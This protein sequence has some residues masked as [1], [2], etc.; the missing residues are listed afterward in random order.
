MAHP[1][2]QAF[3]SDHDECGPGSTDQ[4]R[5]P[6]D[7]HAAFCAKLKSD[8]RKKLHITAADHF[9]GGK[10]SQAKPWQQESGQAI[11]NR[12]Q[13]MREGPADRQDAR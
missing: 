5:V 11:R 6:H 4:E 10:H 3:V 1:P 8:D 13:D 9:Q 2:G 7:S 12:G